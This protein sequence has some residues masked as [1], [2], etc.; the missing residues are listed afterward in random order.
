MSKL[1]T[2]IKFTIYYLINLLLS[3]SK[4]TK[5]KSLL[6]IRLDAIGDYVLFRNF[7]EVLKKSEKYKDYKITL[8]GNSV[9]KSLSEELDSE[10]IEEFIWLDRSKFSKDIVYRYRKLKEISYNG[11]EVLLSPAY[12]REFFVGDAIVKLIE[13]NEKVGSIGDLSNIKKWQKNISDNYYD[14]LVPVK[15]R[16][17]FEF[18][19]NKEFFENLLHTEVD[20]Q[21]PTIQP[22][23][24]KLNLKLPNYYA[25]LFIGASANFRKWDIKNFAKIA[26]HLKEKY[27]YE[28][29]LCGGPT[30]KGDAMEFKKYFKDEYFDLVGKTSLVELLTVIYNGNLMI[31]NET[32]APHFAIALE[33]TNVFVISNGNHYGRFTPYPKEVSECYHVIYHPEIENNLANYRKL[34]NLYGFGSQL[35]ISDI[36]VDRVIKEIDSV[37]I[38][39]NTI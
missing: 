24:K 18:N 27:G 6:L 37:I 20:I 5:K 36:G 33:M 2:L 8:L 32:S 15:E 16:V 26:E 30:D 19:R 31:A 35:N 22:Q 25:V 17:M 13:A 38:N 34:S 4:E 21:K 39:N 7:I 9:W 14:V 11:Y 3:S 10:Y 28:I 23:I 12:S 1:K 29:V